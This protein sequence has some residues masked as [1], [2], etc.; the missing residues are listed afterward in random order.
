VVVLKHTVKLSRQTVHVD[1]LLPCNT[2]PTVEPEVDFGIPPDPQSPTDGHD[3]PDGDSQ[4]LLGMEEDS[5][6]GHS[7][8]SPVCFRFDATCSY[9]TAS[10]SVGDIYSGLESLY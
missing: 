8:L 5:P 9:A 7:V 4:P 1:R 2:P 6:G 10:N 3:I